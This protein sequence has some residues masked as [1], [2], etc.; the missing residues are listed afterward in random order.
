MSTRNSFALASLC[1]ALLAAA[2]QAA[3]IHW[4]P[5]GTQP[6]SGGTGTWTGNVWYDG[7]SY[8]AGATTDDYAI[9][10]GAGTITNSTSHTV[11]SLR[12]SVGGYTISGGGSLIISNAAAGAFTLDP[13]LTLNL[14]SRI[15]YASGTLSLVIGAGSTVNYDS[16]QL[17]GTG[18]WGAT[19]SG[20][21]ALTMKS[22]GFRTTAVGGAS[23]ISGS[24]TALLAEMDHAVQNSSGFLSV[25][26]SG[27]YDLNN[28]LQGDIS[29]ATWSGLLALTVTGSG[30]RVLGG[31]TDSRLTIMAR[32]TSAGTDYG[33]LSVLSSGTLDTEG[34]WVGVFSTGADDSDLVVSG[35]GAIV[36]GAGRMVLGYTNTGTGSD[37]KTISLSL[38]GGGSI[39]GTAASTMALTQNNATAKT[40][41]ITV[42][43]DTTGTDFT[44]S[45][46]IVDGTQAGSG[47]TKAGA[48]ALMLSGIN[49]YT[50]LTTVSAGTLQLSGSLATSKIIVNATMTGGSGTINFTPGDVIDVNGTMDLAGVFFDLSGLNVP[51]GTPVTLLN[52]LD[53][54]IS[55]FA[56]LTF[57]PGWQVTNDTG[58]DLL[59]G[60]LPE[61]ASLA[62]LALAS[63]ALP[64]RRK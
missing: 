53:G 3:T 39:S 43:D 42:A 6:T 9:S 41:T 8:V 12:V 15:Y 13:G 54:N 1:A 11:N 22:G 14:N 44:I 19:L 21:G 28:R 2:A 4:D 64:R 5:D 17:L 48:G 10:A 50:G 32:G 26:S 31:G 56:G 60:V 57:T 34:G 7:S 38:S 18:T 24:G 27:T 61:P 58:A 62:L 30:S 51:I 37:T 35:G 25:E 63:L 49:T 52:Y 40:R 20:G 36:L 33:K 23:K 47:I 59:I 45:A 55:N 16:G 29:G 46:G